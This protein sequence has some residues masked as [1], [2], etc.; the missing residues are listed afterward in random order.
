[1]APVEEASGGAG[2][3]ADDKEAGGLGAGKSSYVPPHMRNGGA[4]GGEKMGGRFEKDD[5]ATLRVTNVRY[6]WF[7]DWTHRVPDGFFFLVL[8]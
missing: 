2:V 5:L 6:L 7:L 8:F 3:D 1:M 4:A